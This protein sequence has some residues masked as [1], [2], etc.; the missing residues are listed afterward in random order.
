M[1]VPEFDLPKEWLTIDE[2]NYERMRKSNDDFIRDREKEQRDLIVEDNNRLQQAIKRIL[3][4]S[5]NF[6]VIDIGRKALRH[7]I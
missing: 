6:T 7:E 1:G 3:Y 4:H 5:T 2:A